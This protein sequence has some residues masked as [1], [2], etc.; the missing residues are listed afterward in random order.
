MHQKISRGLRLFL[1]VTILARR[2]PPQA[3]R[4][5]L[6]TDARS[7]GSARCEVLNDS[8]PPAKPAKA[9]APVR[10]RG[11]SGRACSR[12][13]VLE[14]VA[15]P[16]PSTTQCKS[17][18]LAT[19]NRQ[20]ERT[21][22]RG[23]YGISWCVRAYCFGSSSASR[24]PGSARAS[25]RCSSRCRVRAGDARQLQRVY[26]RHPHCGLEVQPA[27]SKLLPGRSRDSVRFCSTRSRSKSPGL[28]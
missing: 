26:R 18:P 15:L 14:G 22:W 7:P 5:P 25:A 28:Y 21:M 3:P 20:A 2:R 8:P 11:G 23:V 13:Q 17:Q 4:S 27:I 24:Y 6:P 1:P 19:R 16:A 10:A 12:V 9:P